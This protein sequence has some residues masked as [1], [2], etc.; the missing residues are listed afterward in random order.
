MR[1]TSW[2]QVVV[3]EF[4]KGHDTT[5]TTDFCPRQ[6]VSDLL[7]TCHLCCGLVAHLRRE[8]C[9]NGFSPLHSKC[10][11]ISAVLIVLISYIFRHCCLILANKICDK[12]CDSRCPVVKVKVLKLASEQNDAASNVNHPEI[13]LWL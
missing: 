8:N 9:C 7:L 1:A 10:M 6:L 12:T 3:M 4:I 13:N 2:Q 11:T 5:D